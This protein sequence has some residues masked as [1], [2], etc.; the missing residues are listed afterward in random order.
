MAGGETPWSS[1]VPIS[2]PLPS[3]NPIGVA[4]SGFAFTTGGIAHDITAVSFAR[5]ATPDFHPV[6]VPS[7][8][9][10]EDTDIDAPP[11]TM[12]YFG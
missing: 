10:Y 12:E 1:D 8:I 7:E 3:E 9:V 11:S 5:L 6:E 2:M 4:M